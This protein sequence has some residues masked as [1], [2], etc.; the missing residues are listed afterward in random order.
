M[1]I[2]F[3][4]AC[5]RQWRDRVFLSA[6]AA[7]L[8]TTGFMGEGIANAGVFSYSWDRPVDLD[9]AAGPVYVSDEAGVITSV[10]TEFDSDAQQLTF[11]ATFEPEEGTGQLPVGFFLVL[12]D[13]PDPVG[14]DGEYAMLYFDAMT[15]ADPILTAYA[16]NGENGADSFFDGAEG[17][18]NQTPDPIISS[19]NDPSWVDSA[20]SVD[21]PGGRVLS[22][23]I[24]TTA[25]NLHSPMYGTD[26]DWFGMGFDDT[27]GVWLHTYSYLNPAYGA[28]GFIVPDSYSHS[29]LAW[30][31]Y[32]DLGEQFHG[33]FDI[34]YAPTNN[35]IPEPASLAL[36]G[37]G[38][39]ALLSQRRS[40]R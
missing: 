19:L 6:S 21:T 37:M 33:W 38:I 7:A 14:V 25:L 20:T 28:D 40:R 10:T 29:W 18:G 3:S 13:G 11:L 24:D 15:G 34:D 1:G 31:D 30:N 17:P 26:A 39:P 35:P 5:S 23:T 36:L 8:I 16:Y 2:S 32:A 27:I 4:G 22:F 12:N 9:G